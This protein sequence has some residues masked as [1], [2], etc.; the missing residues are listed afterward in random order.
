MIRIQTIQWKNF[1]CYFDYFFII[2]ISYFIDTPR[3]FQLPNVYK[4]VTLRVAKEKS[5]LKCN[6]SQKTLKPN[7]LKQ[8]N[9]SQLEKKA[10]EQEQGFFYYYLLVIK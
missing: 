9:L 3:D 1:V 8:M 6:F 7:E 5:N 10:R 2:K 4:N